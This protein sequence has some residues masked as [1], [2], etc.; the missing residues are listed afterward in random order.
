VLHLARRHGLLVGLTAASLGI[1]CG[2]DLSNIVGALLFI[3]L[4]STARDVPACR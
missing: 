1:V 3:E 2:Y 4:P